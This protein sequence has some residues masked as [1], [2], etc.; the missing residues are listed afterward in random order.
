VESILGPVGTSAIEWPIVLTPGDYDDGEF[1]GMKTGRGNQST[2]RKPTPVPLC[3]PQIPHDLTLARTSEVTWCTHEL[4]A[5]VHQPHDTYF[6]AEPFA[7]ANREGGPLPW[8][9]IVRTEL[10]NVKSCNFRSQDWENEVQI[11][12]KH[13]VGETQNLPSLTLLLWAFG[14]DHTECINLQKM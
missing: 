6:Q 9:R 10:Q 8:I 7:T 4:L 2:R 12:G 13:K 1:G 5:A 14:W 3:P 11:Q